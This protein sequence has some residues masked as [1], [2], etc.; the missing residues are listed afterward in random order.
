MLRG[1]LVALKA[2][3][4]REERSQLNNLIFHFKNLEKEEK[5]KPSSKIK[6]ITKSR[7]QR[8]QKNKKYRKK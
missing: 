6:E 8:I 2:Y 3:I 1:Q 5:N 4:R 7:D